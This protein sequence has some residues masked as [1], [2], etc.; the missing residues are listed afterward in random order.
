MWRRLQDGGDAKEIANTIAS[1]IKGE[2]T[3]KPKVR[4][5]EF[6][7]KCS[8]SLFRLARVRYQEESGVTGNFKRVFLWGAADGI[9]VFLERRI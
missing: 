5:L 6:F 8:V 4:F 9:L 1:A 7:L 3:K 2:K